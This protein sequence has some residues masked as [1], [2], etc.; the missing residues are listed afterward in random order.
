MTDDADE[1]P[2]HRYVPLGYP[3]LTRPERG[4]STISYYQN[5]HLRGEYGRFWPLHL[6]SSHFER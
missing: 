6:V 4:M 5:K 1:K 2:D 3:P